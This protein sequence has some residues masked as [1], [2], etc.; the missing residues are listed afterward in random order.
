VQ[1]AALGYGLHT[2]ALARPVLLSFEIDRFR[3]VSAADINSE[4]LSQAPLGLRELS[5]S[6][7]RLIAAVK[8]A[9]KDDMM[10]S[11]ESALSGFDIS[12][13][14]RN[15]RDFPSQ[16]DAA[17]RAARPVSV[18]LVRYPQAAPDVA[19][20]AATKGTPIDQ[21]RF[22]PVLSRKA[23]WVALVVSPDAQIVGFLPLE[24]FF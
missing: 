8:S 6:G 22:L 13:M 24:G 19:A 5:W 1:L 20:V 9:N 11:V 4:L 16:S 17:W 18:L 15:W 23:S 3:V 14:P 12:T 10:K 21:I 2:I 7:P